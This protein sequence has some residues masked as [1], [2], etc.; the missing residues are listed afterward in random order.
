MRCLVYLNLHAWS[1]SDS[2]VKTLQHGDYVKIIVP[3]PRRCDVSTAEA[4]DDSRTLDL[5]EYWRDYYIPTTPSDFSASSS[6]A[7]SP[8]LAGSADIRRE[9]GAPFQDD[10]NDSAA[11][12]LMQLSSTAASSSQQPPDQA[13]IVEQVVNES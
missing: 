13:V 12:S 6:Q 10:L 7:V 8:S 4:L 5:E 9:F 2:D 11:T 3:P 1:L